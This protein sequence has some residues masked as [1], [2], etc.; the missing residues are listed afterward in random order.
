MKTKIKKKNEIWIVEVDG[1]IKAG[2]EFYL[3][4][5]LENCLKQSEVPK[6]LVDLK[7]VTFVNSAALGIFLST[8]KE[9]ENLNG[10][11]GL[12]SANSDV[13]NLLNLTRINSILEV[14]K[15]QE[16]AYESMSD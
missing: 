10:R 15:N 4:D 11:F 9:V 14:Y 2:D 7:K 13:D 5:D 3:A 1:S 6:I 8:F 16:E 12:C